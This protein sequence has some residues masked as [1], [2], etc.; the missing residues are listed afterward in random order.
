ME[1]NLKIGKKDYKIKILD[2]GELI[3]IKVNEKEFSFPKENKEVFVPLPSKIEKRDFSQKEIS[4]PISG[5]VSDI[6]VK[7]GQEIKKGQ[8][9]LIL[10][11]MK[12]ENEIVSDFDGKVKKILVEK[13][14][15][16]E[17]GQKLVILK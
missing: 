15:R 6:F 2:K 4:A 17:T 13:G 7:E 11:A 5:I 14:K 8:K 10:S 3:S 9:I 16:V 12:M 1:F